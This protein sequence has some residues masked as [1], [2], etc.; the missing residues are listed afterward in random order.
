MWYSALREKPDFVFACA[1]EEAE[2]FTNWREKASLP[3]RAIVDRRFA[4][5]ADG[6]QPFTKVHDWKAAPAIVAPLTAAQHPSHIAVLAGNRSIR[7]TGFGR[8]GWD[9]AVVATLDDLNVESLADVCRLFPGAERVIVVDRDSDGRSRTRL[10]HRAEHQW[11]L[12][13][14]S[15]LAR[16]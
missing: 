3:E 10:L 12:G 5:S 4:A 8:H 16:I 1:D 9:A 11:I 13:S 2:I 6:W 15:E 14:T 7:C